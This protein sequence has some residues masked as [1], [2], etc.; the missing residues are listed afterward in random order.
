MFF[1]FSFMEISE[2][3]PSP[4]EFGFPA[5]VDEVADRLPGNAHVV[6]KLGLVVCCQFGS[7][8]EFNNDSLEHPD[9]LNA[10]ACFPARGG[11]IARKIPAASEGASQARVLQAVQHGPEVQ[12]VGGLFFG[13]LVLAGWVIRRG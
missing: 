10:Q 9:P 5:V 6:E 1:L 8:L 12:R 7:G 3:E 2:K 11:W 4:L 13:S